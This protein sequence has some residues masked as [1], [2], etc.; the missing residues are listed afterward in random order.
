VRLIVFAIGENVVVVANPSFDLGEGLF[1][2]IQI[3]GVGQEI[4]EVHA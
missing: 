3:A 4:H 1:N 2:G